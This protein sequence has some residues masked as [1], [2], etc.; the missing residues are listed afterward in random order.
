MAKVGRF[1]K[2]PKGGTD[3]S[4]AI[5][6]LIQ[7]YANER[8]R[9]IVDA[10]TNGG[11]FEGKKVTDSML[12]AFYADKQKNLDP[13]DPEYDRVK[14]THDQYKFAV[15]NSEMEMKYA[16]KG[17]SD[18]GMS[19]FYA[20]EAAKNPRHSE[21][22][23]KLMTLSGQYA[24]RARAASTTGSG[25]RA[26]RTAALHGEVDK[27]GSG[28][29]IWKGFVQWVTSIAHIS[30]ALNSGQ[31]LEGTGGS[32]LSDLQANQGDYSNL[33]EYMNQL[34][35]GQGDYWVQ[36]RAQFTQWARKIDPHFDGSF[37]PAAIEQMRTRARDGMTTR[38]TLAKKQGTAAQVKAIGKG[39]DSTTRI[40]GILETLPLIGQYEE[41]N[42]RYENIL[43]DVNS[44]TSEIEMAREHYVSVIT[45]ISQSL[46]ILAMQNITPGS[47]S[48]DGDRIAAIAGKMNNEIAHLNGDTTAPYSATVAEE[49]RGQL[50]GSGNSSS[51]D[52]SA[53]DVNFKNLQANL[54]KLTTY[55]PDGLPMFVE[56]RDKSGWTV[57]S[58]QEMQAMGLPLVFA[59][60]NDSKE[61][62]TIGDKT[63]PVGGTMTA[64]AGQPVTAVG[65]SAAS[66]GVNVPTEW[67]ALKGQNP[68][69]MT[70]FDYP[71]GTRI[72]Q[73]YDA[74][75]KLQNSAHN[76][77]VDGADLVKGPDGWSLRVYSD[78]G[79]ADPS[80]KTQAGGQPSHF[81]PR[82]ALSP[83]FTDPAAIAGQAGTIS[84]SAT[85][86]HMLASPDPAAAAFSD[87]AMILRLLRAESGGNEA[88][89]QQLV[90]GNDIAR[91]AMLNALPTAAYNP[92]WLAHLTPEQKAMFPSTTAAIRAAGLKENPNM[93]TNTLGL[94]SSR[95]RD[96]IVVQRRRA[97]SIAAPAD[98]STVA[99][100]DAAQLSE[101]IRKQLADQQ[102]HLTRDDRPR[103]AAVGPLDPTAPT[104]D[105]MAVGLQYANLPPNG[106][107]NQQTPPP[108]QP[109][110]PGNPYGP[111]RPDIRPPAPPPPPP[112]PP[113][114]TGGYD[115][116]SRQRNF[117]PPPPPRPPASA[118]RGV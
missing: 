70:I 55:G 13:S 75:G 4:A 79:V 84:D 87:P 83:G 88:L 96:S 98:A 31:A 15:R 104:G 89:Y 67:A 17:V 44:T 69:V 72:Y 33:N 7:Q 78:K 48:A 25:G 117:A 86:A 97:L 21:Q 65:L 85:T 110:A 39:I 46:N 61:V 18:S 115:E 71:D 1:G 108:P 105:P 5:T 32:D 35:S 38:L 57:K 59:P 60:S 56:W 73:Y 101:Y 6:S 82:S 118:K 53:H 106:P 50:T 92:L 114:P 80:V 90:R 10:W 24:E 40:G 68:V 49:S 91:S 58:T 99:G 103:I 34:A 20:N 52:M 93:D 36:L 94:P 23:R 107:A 81:S 2:L 26:A 37:T 109:A 43:N 111:P 77:A 74:D 51:G 76:P 27:Q 29:Q 47:P 100:M 30:G 45:P 3:L 22:Y 63:F 19:S 42:R 41:A 54:A 112:P 64:I 95:E 16:K 116:S 102:A 14:N 62:L 66:N 28:E 113:M 9:N 12:L 11:E 8:E